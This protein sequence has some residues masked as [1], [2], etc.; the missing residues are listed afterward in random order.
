MPDKPL[1]VLTYAASASL[2]AVALIYF[3]NPSYIIDGEG[4][5]NQLSRRARINS[6]IGLYN[7][8][9]DCF[10]NSNLQAL[11]GL[12]ELRLYLI[13]E[14]HRR[15][16]DK[17]REIYKIVDEENEDGKPFDRRKAQ[18]LLDAELTRGLK[19][20]LDRLNERPTQK[21]IISATAFIQA[22]ESSYATS[23]N[24]YQQDAQELLQIVAERLS[25]EYAVGRAARKRA[26]EA[27]NG[28]MKQEMKEIAQDVQES[29]QR[30][31]ENQDERAEEKEP[32]HT[33]GHTA[34]IPTTLVNGAAVEKDAQGESTWLSKEESFPME[35]H[36]KSQI[37]CQQCRFVPKSEPSPFIMLTLSVPHGK[38]S[39]S[40]NE[41]FDGYFKTEHIDDYRCDRCR[42]VHAVSIFEKDL[43]KTTK[44]SHRQ[45]LASDIARLKQAIEKDPETPPEDIRLPKDAP[46]RRI[47]RSVA[48]TSFPKILVVHL[49]R[50]SFESSFSSKV[51]AK[52]VFPE[53]LTLGGLLN[54]KRYR[55][56]GLVTHKGSHYSGHYET[57]R[58]Q[59]IYPPNTATGNHRESELHGHTEKFHL[60]SATPE[61]QVSS[62][63]DT[64]SS[65]SGSEADRELDIPPM[66][67]S[68][69]APSSTSRP[70]PTDFRAAT[71]STVTSTQ[72]PSSTSPRDSL[73]TLPTPSSA[74]HPDSTTTRVDTPASQQRRA[75]S[76][77]T[78][79]GSRQ[80]VLDKIEEAKEQKKADR[81]RKLALKESQRW[82]RIS[83]DKVKECKTGDVLHMQKE[84]YM[85]FYEMER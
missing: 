43:S 72:D 32:D 37:E 26:R 53:H 80:R 84:A 16:L 71:P 50:S 4:S 61:P 41:C 58:R 81:R 24:R 6:V 62:P 8:R 12:G 64:P 85:L 2:A 76:E 14:L 20:M 23:I 11:A 60:V 55:L 65:G 70:R 46:K 3:F 66:S 38:S 67:N 52:V 1:T 7:P 19:D 54:R 9:N 33:E 5:A 82:W 29:E 47:A 27:S 63:T 42:L 57:F 45:E 78:R 73:S 77:Q 15:D 40:L 59:H 49:S 18:S 48:I 28:G 34:P 51:E 39:A 35:G 79:T 44:E 22:L 21:K 36:T 68:H 83:D 10:I 69:E 13:R 25:D 56:L 74:L 30:R 75:S 17:E 31:T